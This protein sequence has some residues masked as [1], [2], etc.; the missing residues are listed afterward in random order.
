MNLPE[1]LDALNATGTRL[2][3][4]GGDL[5]VDAPKG[6]MT[7]DIRAGLGIH[8]ETLLAALG[9]LNRIEERPPFHD[10]NAKLVRL[11]LDWLW[12]LAAEYVSGSVRGPEDQLWHVKETVWRLLDSDVNEAWIDEAYQFYWAMVE[13]RPTLPT[14]KDVQAIEAARTLSDDDAEEL[15]A[16]FEE[17]NG[18]IE[19]ADQ[20]RVDTVWH[21]L[22]KFNTRTG[23]AKP[24]SPPPVGRGQGYRH[25]PPAA[26]CDSSDFTRGPT[27]PLPGITRGNGG[28]FSGV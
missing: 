24:S 23:R 14:A 25:A 22:N 18:A 9:A 19:A 16:I 4:S 11:L 17:L 3:I 6:A 2:A 13:S 27:F 12:Y 20:S 15:R 5:Q 7:P 1:L 26:T 21:R 10:G 8:R 28:L